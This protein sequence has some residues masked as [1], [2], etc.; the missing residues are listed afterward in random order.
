VAQKLAP[1]MV[2]GADLRPGLKQEF[3]NPPRHADI[4]HEGD[5]SQPSSSKPAAGRP[6]E[7]ADGAS[8]VTARRMA[9]SQEPTTPK[10][11]QGHILDMVSIRR[12]RPAEIE[13]RRPCRG[14]GKGDLLYCSERTRHIATLVERNTPRFT[15]LVKIPRKDN[16]DCCCC[17]WQSKSASCLRVATLTDLGSRQSR[18]HAPQRGIQRLPPTSQGL[19][20]VD[21]RSPWQTRAQ[22]RTPTACCVS[23]PSRG[24]TDFLRRIS[25]SYLNCRVLWRLNQRPRKDLGLS[26]RQPIDYKRVLALTGLKRTTPESRH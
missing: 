25:Q 10:S 24:G 4:S 20:S 26:K 12:A 18:L 11:G 16:D 23:T 1:A 22:T 14:I 7:G 13:D 3:P 17:A 6:E 15:M 19:L 9:S 8:C 21:P 2:A 5:L